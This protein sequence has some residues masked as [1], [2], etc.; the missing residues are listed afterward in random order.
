M[1][2]AY[3]RPTL[4]QQVRADKGS[5]S[6]RAYAREHGVGEATVRRWLS[7]TTQPKAENAGWIAAAFSALPLPV[8]RAV[9][10]DP[11]VEARVRANGIKIDVHYVSSGHGANGR[12]RQ[13]ERSATL[14]NTNLRFRPG[15]GDKVM[16]LWL[17]GDSAGAARALRDGIGDPVYRNRFF[18]DDSLIDGEED[19]AYE[20]QADDD[21]DSPP[22][23]AVV[24]MSA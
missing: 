22:G 16:D 13:R 19:L 14:S 23:L 11:A 18:G 4:A 24:G 10:V 21:G 1:L 6:N 20:G 9:M 3:S 17:K 7:G 2:G 5:M 15:T 12:G 8:R